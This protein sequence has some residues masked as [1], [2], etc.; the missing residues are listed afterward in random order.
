VDVSDVIQSTILRLTGI[1]SASGIVIRS[2]RA[3]TALSTPITADSV[4]SL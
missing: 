1:L 2:H 3:N 4:T